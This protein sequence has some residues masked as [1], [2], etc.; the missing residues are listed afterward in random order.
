VLSCI[1][2][3]TLL[4]PCVL[5]SL[6][7]SEHVYVSVCVCIRPDGPAADGSAAVQTSKGLLRLIIRPDGSAADTL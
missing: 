4:H 6:H 2:S 5:V 7:V 1:V 3:R